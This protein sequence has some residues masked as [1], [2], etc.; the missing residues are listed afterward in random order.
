VEVEVPQMQIEQEIPVDL[1]VE[2]E[3]TH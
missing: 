2:V 1:V 3:I